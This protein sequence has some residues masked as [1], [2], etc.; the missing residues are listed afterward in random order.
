MWSQPIKGNPLEEEVSSNSCDTEGHHTFPW[1][2]VFN[3]WPSKS[4][5]GD[6]ILIIIYYKWV[7]LAPPTTVSE[8]VTSATGKLITHSFWWRTARWPK[9]ALP[10]SQ[11][12]RADCCGR[13]HGIPH[14]HQYPFNLWDLWFRIPLP[15]K[16]CLKR[17]EEMITTTPYFFCHW[18]FFFIQ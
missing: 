1:L 17:N 14:R 2:S 18:T 13:F 10:L 11:T 5:C 6:K 16:T 12:D 9:L 4:C 3:W 8:W 7:T 15:Q